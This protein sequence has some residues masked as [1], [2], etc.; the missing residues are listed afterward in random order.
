M[1][2]GYWVLFDLLDYNITRFLM[3]LLKK[4]ANGRENGYMWG[5]SKKKVY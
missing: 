4:A 2:W 1:G 5:L 3:S